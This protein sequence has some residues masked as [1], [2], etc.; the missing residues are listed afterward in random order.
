VTQ[1]AAFR[2]SQ[3]VTST[4]ICE[5]AWRSAVSPSKKSRHTL[6]NGWPATDCRPGTR[7]QVLVFSYRAEWEGRIYGEKEVTVY[8]KVKEG[9]LILL[10][11]KARY[12]EGFLRGATYE[13]RI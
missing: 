13:D 7:G 4:H 8:Y 5:L 2:C 11:V 12:G 3:R 10:T 1:Q 6:K 9:Q